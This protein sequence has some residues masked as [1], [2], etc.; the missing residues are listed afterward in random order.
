LTSDTPDDKPVPERSPGSVDGNGASS[1]PDANGTQNYGDAAGV[2]RS[3]P[4]PGHPNLRPLAPGTASLNPGGRVSIKPL[5]EAMR[6]F[7]DPDSPE[8]QARL[9]ELLEALHHVAKNPNRASLALEAQGFL[10]DTIDG[11]LERAATVAPGGRGPSNLVVRFE[12]IDNPPP[13]TVPAKVTKTIPNGNGETKR[14]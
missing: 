14:E 2:I 10:R 8:G 4:P 5:R 9:R 3:P 12:T 13:R 1:K 6:R 7:Y 11:P